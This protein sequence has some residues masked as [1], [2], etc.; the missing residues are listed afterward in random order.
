MN[1]TSP[2]AELERFLNFVDACFQEHKSV[3]DTVNQEDRRLQDLLHEMEFAAD[4]AERNRVAT[5]MQRSRRL[6]R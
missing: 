4:K 1:R 2:A 3:Y 6:R 5:R